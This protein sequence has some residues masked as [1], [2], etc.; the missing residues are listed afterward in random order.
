MPGLQPGI[1]YLIVNAFQ[2]GTEATV[3]LTLSGEPET[4]T[5]I[6]NNGIDTTAMRQRSTAPTQSA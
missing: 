1:Y 4:I 5:E 2:M 3:N 6:C